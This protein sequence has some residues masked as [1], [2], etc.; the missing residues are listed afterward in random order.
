M[1]YE[2][3]LL[4]NSVRNLEI[5]Q[6]KINLNSTPSYITIGA[7]YSC[8]ASCVFCL[9]GDYPDFSL[10]KY[11]DFFEPKI[12]HILKKAINVGFCGFGEI[13]LHPEII[14]IL[15]Y[16]S[17]TL[18]N[19]SKAFTTNGIM[20]NEKIC[21]K[22]TD[23]RYD[24]MISLHASNNVLHEKITRTKKFNDIVKNIKRLV[25]LKKQ[26]QS[27]I[28]I[29]M[30]FVITQ[31]NIDNLCDFIKFSKE[32]ETDCVSA[33]YLTMYEP[34]HVDMSVFWIKDKVN[35]I[36]EQAEK[37]REELSFSVNL[38]LKFQEYSKADNIACRDPWEF[39][40]TEVQGSVNPCCLA[41]NH[42][43]NLNSNGFEEI[44]NSEGYVMLREGIASG[45]I[46]TW[47]K[48]CLKYDKNNVNKLL[49]HIT[50]RPET[51]QLL[52]KYIFKNNNK[53]NLKKEDIGIIDFAI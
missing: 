46:H 41:G 4:N 51:Q 15:D 17:E 49:S 30:V 20:L 40:Y 7:H 50:F 23:G 3:I 18:P 38:P 22:L 29:N 9:G 44:W 53:Y 11:K 52:L 1:N 36:L 37:L 43:G 6:K 8:N 5:E 32:L 14:P 12:G 42:I 24:V 33:N 19:Q 48:N 26:K 47:C 25:E 2:K 21:Q 16:L 13:L 28:S 31:D 34:N 45:N 10:A 27:K 35:N 39:F